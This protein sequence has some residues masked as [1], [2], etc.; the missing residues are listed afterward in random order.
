M[1]RSQKPGNNASSARDRV[2]AGFFHATRFEAAARRD[3]MCREN[4]RS[5][6]EKSTGGGRHGLPRRLRQARGSACRCRPG[7]RLQPGTAL[8]TSAQE[9]QRRSRCRQAEEQ[10]LCASAVLQRTRRTAAWQARNRA[11]R[12]L[13]GA[14]GKN[15]KAGGSRVRAAESPS[16]GEAETAPGRCRKQ[17]TPQNRRRGGNNR[18][19]KSRGRDEHNRRRRERKSHRAQTTP[20]EKQL[21]PQRTT[22]PGPDTRPGARVRPCSAGFTP[23]FCSNKHDTPRPSSPRN[24]TRPVPGTQK[25]AFRKTEVLQ[26]A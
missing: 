22:Q 18:R 6:M 14:E 23:R 12:T 21:P 25:K 24:G 20:G 1:T 2:P 26:N 11:Q 7:G 16:S 10:I 9:R 19:L 3:A 13:P 17:A 4:A 5:S 8:S 15:G